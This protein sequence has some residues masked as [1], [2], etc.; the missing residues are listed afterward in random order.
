M[1]RN[2]MLA[3]GIAAIGAASLGDARAQAR[4]DGH[5]LDDVFKVTVSAFQTRNTTTSL[6]IDSRTLGL[7]TML[8]AESDLNVED[9]VTGS[10]ADGYYRFNK[11]N[12]IE[13][14]FYSQNREG[15][16][17]LLDRN[18]EL[19]NIVIPINYSVQSKLDFDIAKI[20]YAWSFVN[21]STYELFLGAG[22][23]VRNISLAFRGVGPGPNPGDTRTFE[24]QEALPLPTITAGIRYNISHA[25]SVNFR[26]ENFFLGVDRNRGR[27]Q[28]TYLLV[29]YDFSKRFGL[30][31]GINNYNIDVE[32]ELD[33]GYSGK[34]ESS[35]FGFLL[36]FTAG[37]GE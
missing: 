15:T 29:E 1:G 3:C 8:E 33:D 32:M 23:N 14:T 31:G 25:L 17:S 5:E 2:G 21:T 12:R 4:Y 28:D 13:W 16:R 18:I 35:Y 36:F 11:A 27:M 6:R 10:R 37:F 7:G 34:L 19:G 9:S 26:A 30:G 24:T 22:L 20:G